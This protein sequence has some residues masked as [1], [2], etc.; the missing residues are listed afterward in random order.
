MVRADPQGACVRFPR[1]FKR[2]AYAGLDQ[3]LRR[4]VA[5]FAGKKVMVLVHVRVMHLDIPSEVH[6]LYLFSKKTKRVQGLKL[7]GQTAAIER[8]IRVGRITADFYSRRGRI[9]YEFLS[10]Q[11]NTKSPWPV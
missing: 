8:E 11:F 2:S 3:E 5:R 9:R 1:L 10:Y 4:L 6:V 7:S